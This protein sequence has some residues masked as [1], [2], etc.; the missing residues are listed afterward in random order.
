MGIR[1]RLRYRLL[2][3]FGLVILLAIIL[4]GI[5]LNRITAIQKNVMTINVETNPMVESVNH[6]IQD[7]QE[8]EIMAQKTRLIHDAQ[9]LSV[10]AEN[11]NQLS[12]TYDEEFTALTSLVRDSDILADLNY[13]D[14]NSQ[15]F[16]QHFNQIITAQETV[17]AYSQQLI[18]LQE[19]YSQ[20]GIT[21]H[22]T[23][24]ND[25]EMTRLR[26][27]VLQQQTIVDKTILRED[28]NSIVEQKN[29]FD[30][31]HQEILGLLG[32]EPQTEIATSVARQYEL[33]MGAEGIFQILENRLRA[34]A[35][36][37]DKA[38]NMDEYVQSLTTGFEDVIL[39]IED[40][41]Q[42]AIQSTEKQ[43]RDSKITISILSLLIMVIGIMIALRLSTKI[44][45][46][47][48][49]MSSM[50]DD[51]TRK[52]LTSFVEV[53]QGIA[54]GELSCQLQIQTA[55]I[56]IE[57]HDE[58]GDVGNALNRMVDQLQN[59]AS[60]SQK[61]VND[62][63]D[64]FLHIN[65]DVL[66]LHTSSSELKQVSQ[67][68]GEA[69]GQIATT[70]QQVARSTS[71]QTESISNMADT[72]E[73]LTRLINCVAVGGEDQSI[74]IQHTLET[75]Q[76]M[77][78]SIN[79][80][81]EMSTIVARTA[82][83]ASALSI[84]GAS[85]VFETVDEMQTI[86]QK[87]D[88]SATEVLK[89]GEITTHIGVIV[90]TIDDIASQTHLLALNAS[91]EAA[92]AGEHGKG[93]AVVAEEVGKLASRSADATKEIDKLVNDVQGTVSKAIQ[94]MQESAHE[95]E[96][97]VN[98]ARSAGDA[99]Q[100]IKQAIDTVNEQASNAEGLAN[101]LTNASSKLDGQTAVIARV[102]ENNLIT[103]QEMRSSSSEVIDIVENLASIA[104]Q[105]SA[106]V[107]EVSAS[108][109]E[110]SAQAQE[111]TRS[112]EVLSGMADTLAILLSRFDLGGIREAV[113]SLPIFIE[114]HEKWLELAQEIAAGQHKIDDELL[115]QAKNECALQQW[116]NG[117]GKHIIQTFNCTSLLDAHHTFHE[118]F[119]SLLNYVQNDN[120]QQAAQNLERM[121]ENSKIIISCLHTIVENSQTEIK[122][123]E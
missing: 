117:S 60:A 52:D 55:K 4:G 96:Q 14:S 9:A 25:Q 100:Q 122:K 113:D 62:I 49:K 40:L 118:K 69:S 76:S 71:E 105:N 33:A 107:E 64:I 86:K 59:A 43:V 61:M 19:S 32:E 72:I 28:V 90:D 75:I 48:E 101:Q 54:A 89:M 27:T 58:L 110:M 67:E 44:S 123:G 38:K 116:I 21:L 88:I 12:I 7:M 5:G 65:K 103:I 36:V 39:E 11:V 63:R 112:S 78:H 119:L 74:A 111:I 47:T 26:N 37:D 79:G 3:N 80:E 91:I 51:I 57:S 97:G 22:E 34:E 29:K 85:R 2:I 13:V 98:R 104:E 84:Q 8:L 87:V 99:L 35:Y 73:N 83:E 115:I 46:F 16:L 102:V 70:I 31:I 121:R 18:D 17:I 120:W 20:T 94:S 30:A 77:Q 45:R 1:L 106:A 109:E 50:A 53:M 68:S 6:L 42:Q 81:F 10:M 108:T 41:N 93:F 23:I 24:Q 15:N 92:R 56:E 114:S 66:Q 82:G 95:V